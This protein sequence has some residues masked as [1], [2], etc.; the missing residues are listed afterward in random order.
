MNPRGLQCPHDD[1]A[2][3][4]VTDKSVSE[5]ALM[6]RGACPGT[7]SSALSEALLHAACRGPFRPTYYS[8]A[9]AR[10]KCRHVPWPLDLA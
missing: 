6:G 3:D 10:Q 1:C 7:S 5:K 2:C 4:C 9:F 8:F